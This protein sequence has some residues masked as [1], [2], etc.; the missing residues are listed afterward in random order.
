MNYTLA[1]WN[2]LEVTIM[3]LLERWDVICSYHHYGFSH[4]SHV[5]QS[6]SYSGMSAAVTMETEYEIF[7]IFLLH[8]CLFKKYKQ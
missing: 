6:F 4:S 3:I 8:D 2:L 1:I 7:V 5:Q